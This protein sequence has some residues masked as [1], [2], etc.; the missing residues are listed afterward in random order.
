MSKSAKKSTHITDYNIH[1]PDYKSITTKENA[2]VCTVGRMNPP[3]PGHMKLVRR[4]ILTAVELN[5]DEVLVFL[6]SNNKDNKNPLIC[7]EDKKRFLE[8]MTELMQSKMSEPAKS[9]HVKFECF[10]NPVVAIFGKI[11]EMKDALSEDP[12]HIFM[13]LGEDRDSISSSLIKKPDPRVKMHEDLL[14]RSGMN[15]RI[16]SLT[17]ATETPS[18]SSSDEEDASISGTYVRGLVESGNL[19]AFEKVYSNY[20]QPGDARELFFSIK[21]GMAKFHAEFVAKKPEDAKPSRYSRRK[22]PS[23]TGSPGKSARKSPSPKTS[24]GKSARKSPSPK[25]SPKSSPKPSPKTSPKSSPKSSP[26]LEFALPIPPPGSPPKTR[27]SAR[28]P[29]IKRGGQWTRKN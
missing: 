27:R 15:E 3:T 11:K 10:A 2:L 21:S 1:A 13:T 8:K 26:T 18:E 22:R 23:P 14:P 17:S 7:E 20:L 16:A 28:L 4:L 5:L 19:D 25:S 12:V 24:P 29:P 6:S 9:V